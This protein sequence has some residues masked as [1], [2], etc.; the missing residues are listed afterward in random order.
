MNARIDTE[1]TPGPAIEKQAR[2]PFIS[3]QQA[4]IYTANLGPLCK[5]VAGPIADGRE[6]GR[7]S[8]VGHCHCIRRRPRCLE[9]KFL[10]SARGHPFMTSALRG[11]GGLENLLILWTN[12]TDRLREM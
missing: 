12:R 9:W 3:V 10:H 6:G 8:A 2:A 4:T 7:C 5:K 11:E 1:S